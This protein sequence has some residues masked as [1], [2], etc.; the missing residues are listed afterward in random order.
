VSE[1][2]HAEAG[3]EDPIGGEQLAGIGAVAALTG[4][5]ERTLRY[6]EE[7]GLVSPRGHSPGGMRRYCS[8][9]IER[10]RRIRELQ[11]LMGFNLEEIRGVMG[12]E[13]RLSALR[14][15][16]RASEDRVRQREVLDEA[17]EVLGEL[18]SAA[19]TKVAALQSFLD[20]LDERFERHRS[21]LEELNQVGDAVTGDAV[22]GDAVTGD[23]V[24]GRGS[25]GETLG[26]AAASAVEAPA[27]RSRRGKTSGRT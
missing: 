3:S 10:V 20:D 4:V 27:A 14:E 17:L 2:R 15:D 26:P 24:T 21:R 5:S 6:Y 18:R 22:S 11:G 7:I 19:Q 23:A 12:A 1:A 16:F 13:S 8:E 25:D 9:D